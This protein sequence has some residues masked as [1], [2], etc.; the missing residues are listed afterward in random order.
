MSP[1]IEVK[2]SIKYHLLWL[3]LGK[4]LLLSN[5]SSTLPTCNAKS[6]FFLENLGI[7]R[8][9]SGSRVGK[10]RVFF[11]VLLNDNLEY[12]VFLNHFWIADLCDTSKE[13]EEDLT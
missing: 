4:E 2:I 1:N 5:G 7:S 3:N 11:F 9:C 13:L 12:P 10:S 6:V 8:V